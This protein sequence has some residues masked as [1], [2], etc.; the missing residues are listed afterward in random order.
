MSGTTDGHRAARS[1]A[2]ARG[3]WL[4]ALT[5]A[6][7]YLYDLPVN[8]FGNE[9]YAAASWAG[10]RDLTALAFGSL[11]PGNVVSVDKPPLG[12]LVPALSARVLGFSSWSLLA[13][14]A[15]M[16]VA[17]ALAVHATVRR[18]TGPGAALLAGTIMAA[19]PV[20]AMMFRHNNPDAVTALAMTVGTWC[21]VRAARTASTPWLLTAAAVTGAG[22]LAK[23][24][25]AFLHLPALVVLYLLCA[26]ASL[27]RKLAQLGATLGVLLVSAGWY[28]LL[29]ELWPRDRRP[30]LGG[31]T[32][33]SLLQ[34][35]WGYNGVARMAGGARR[36]F[37][38]RPGPW[39][40]FQGEF[41]IEI[42]W[43]L[44]AAVVAV[45]A[46]LHLRRAQ[47]RQDLVRGMAV[48]SA[49]WLATGWVT[50][51]FMRGPT[52]AYYSLVLVPPVAV[53]VPLA[54][55]EVGR[56]RHEP[57]GRAHA[58]ALVLTA[59]W[60]VH[61]LRH[62]ERGWAP[63]L[64]WL[65]LAAGAGALLCL[66]AADRHP[67]LWRATLVLGLVA[68][69]ATPLAY[70]L[71]GLTRPHRGPSPSARPTDRLLAGS[72]AASARPAPRS[73]ADQ[74]P[75]VVS[76]LA[77]STHDWAAAVP[78][79]EEAARYQLAA[80]V[81]VMA[82]GGYLGSDPAPTLEDFRTRARAG[83]VG[84]YLARPRPAT[85]R[86]RPWTQSARIDAWVRATCSARVLDGLL[87]YDLHTCQ[88]R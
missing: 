41:G 75:Q 65:V 60:A 66:G 11:D 14:Q 35:A 67:V 4:L 88:G 63:W 22:F 55:H 43:L 29:V 31:S 21:A 61:L 33:D 62:H 71:A 81:P 82:I 56:V 72:P 49:V 7:C 74:T 44:P 23:M 83:R 25:G 47:P 58:A 17:A 85:P 15:L 40:L 9:Y 38:S 1:W 86:R 2:R 20:S 70:S 57:A 78:G 84:Y 19:T 13:P 16:G 6:T 39:R 53:V 73:P 32:D 28:P 10:T 26:P 37:G 30:Y 64:G 50:L 87:I 68:L 34:L 76:L 5:V 48:M 36:A 24:L 42:S 69:L 18:E 54:V 79:A 27:R 3:A 45:V 12:V 59:A 77:A 46:V 8:G 52:H 51:S 80:R